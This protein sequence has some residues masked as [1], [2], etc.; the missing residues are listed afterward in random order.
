M[1]K[2]ELTLQRT[3]PNGLAYGNTTGRSTATV[4]ILIFVIASHDAEM[5]GNQMVC[6]LSDTEPFVSHPAKVVGVQWSAP[7]L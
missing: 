3:F 7:S 5:K 2:T 1:V 6:A 4:G